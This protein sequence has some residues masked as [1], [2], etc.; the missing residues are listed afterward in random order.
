MRIAQI[1]LANAQFSDEF[2]FVNDS[3]AIA[4]FA[5]LNSHWSPIQRK[6]LVRSAQ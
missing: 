3:Y 5:P 2:S 1:L 4:S 6:V